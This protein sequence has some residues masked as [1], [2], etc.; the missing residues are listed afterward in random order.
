[1]ATGPPSMVYTV[2]SSSSLSTHILP[3]HTFAPTTHTHTHT[4]LQSDRQT[5][6]HAGERPTDRTSHS[7]SA[8]TQPEL[9]VYGQT[10]RPTLTQADRQT[11]RQAQTF[12]KSSSLVAPPS[13]SSLSLRPCS[14]PL[15]SHTSSK[16]KTPALFFEQRSNA[17]QMQVYEVTKNI[18]ILFQQAVHQ[19]PPNSPSSR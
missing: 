18:Y 7:Q 2:S 1:M 19:T 4:Q 17:K 8:E 12:N 13:G 10:D 5:D 15:P 3:K 11:E 6:R 9:Q 14:P 16:S